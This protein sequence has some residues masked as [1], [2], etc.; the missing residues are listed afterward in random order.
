M[1]QIAVARL[2]HMLYTFYSIGPKVML[3]D[4]RNDSEIEMVKY[5][6]ATVPFACLS[7]SIICVTVRLF[8]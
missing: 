1:I 2:I 7:R 3:D 4:I 5:L 6:S 8:N